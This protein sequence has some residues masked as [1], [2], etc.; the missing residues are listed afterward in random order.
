MAQIKERESNIELLR[1]I[2]M[3]MI[4]GLH[5]NMFAIGLPDKTNILENP[6]NSFTRLFFEYLCII[7][8]NVFVLISGWFGIKFKTKGLYNFLFQ[9]LFISIILFIP[10]AI[11]GDVELNRVNILSIF[12]LY[13]NAYWFVWAY[14]V[15]YILSPVLNAFVENA[16]KKVYRKVLF[17]FF[18]VQTV[19]FV[20]T[21]CGFY[22][23]GYNPLSFIGLYLLMRYIRKWPIEINKNELLAIWST[24]TLVNF[25]LSCTGNGTLTTISLAYTNPLNIISATA[26]VLYFTKLSFK[27]KVIN[28]ISASC[29]AVYL[30]HMHFCIVRYYKEFAVKIYDNYG[31]IMYLAH[32]TLFIIAVFAI[33]VL[34]DKVRIWA[35]DKFWNAIEKKGNVTQ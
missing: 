18:T 13:K 26:L 14:L 25:A 29:F 4:L 30:V 35:F 9:P 21:S 10:C 11:N 32:I 20:F 5:V 2:A 27:S 6:L 34:I 1:I 3:F 12:L 17:L 24:C 15:L 28:Y 31:G 8:V 33:S 7:G 23:A 22:D 19:I 16:E